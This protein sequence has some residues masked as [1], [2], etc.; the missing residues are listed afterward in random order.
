[1]QINLNYKKRNG[2]T[3]IE[4][5]V[6]MSI[7]AIFVAIAI[8]GFI[9]SLSSQRLILKLMSATD[10]MTFPLEQISREVRVGSDFQS[11]GPNNFVNNFYFNRVEG[12]G[13]EGEDQ[14]Y[15]IMYSYDSASHS[16]VRKKTLLINGSP[17]G[18]SYEEKIT[19]DNIQVDDFRVRVYQLIPSGP[20]RIVVLIAVS[21]VDKGVTIT[22]HIQT[23]LSSRLF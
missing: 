4:L 1:M 6:A 23:T 13:V 9:Q 21:A 15:Q 16:I 11:S 8:G 20:Y 7:F 22:N 19:P 14:E 5:L 12:S 17:S 2:S 18:T 3:M 10:G